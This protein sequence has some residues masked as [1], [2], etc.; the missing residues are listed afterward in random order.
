VNHKQGSNAG[1]TPLRAGPS[2]FFF[3]ALVFQL[4]RERTDDKVGHCRIYTKLDSK[5]QTPLALHGEA[6][7]SS[8]K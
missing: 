3:Q 1:F 4:V 6:S 2:P 5:R 8:K 7:P